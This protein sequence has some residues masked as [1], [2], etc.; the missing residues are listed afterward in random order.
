MWGG[1]TEDVEASSDI[2]T[3][4]ANEGD[5]ETQY[6]ILDIG[7][8][9]GSYRD[10]SGNLNRYTGYNPWATITGYNGANYDYYGNGEGTGSLLG[11]GGYADDWRITA[12]IPAEDFEDKEL[13]IT[14]P[15]DS[16]LPE[17]DWHD[18]RSTFYIYGNEG[19]DGAVSVL[20]PKENAYDY[21]LVGW[22]NIGTGEYYSVKNGNAE[23]T[24]NTEDDNIFY[25]DWEAATY[26]V[27]TD[28]GNVANTV[29][30]DFVTINLFDYNEL[31]NLYSTNYTSEGDYNSAGSKATTANDKKEYWTIGDTFNTEPLGSTQFENV[32]SFAFYDG[33]DARDEVGMLGFP[34]NRMDQSNG[35]DGNQRD[36]TEYQGNRV[37]ITDH[38]G[39]TAWDDAFFTDYLF[40]KN[41]ESDGVLGVDYIGQADQLFKYGKEGDEIAEENGYVG[42]YYYD[43]RYNSASYNQSEGRFYVYNDPTEVGDN[44]YPEGF[45]PYNYYGDSLDDHDGSVNYF[46]GM[47]M[48]VNFYLPN[49]VG[50]QNGNTVD[51]KDM[52]FNFSGDD[53][54]WIFV[55]DE[56]MLDMSGIHNKSYGSI[57]FCTGAVSLQTT[58]TA[59]NIVYT[60]ENINDISGL[61]AGEHTLRVYY[62]ERGGDASNMIVSFNV[63]P[64][65][66]YESDNVGTVTVDKEWQDEDG[67][68]L[69]GTATAGCPDV[70]VGLYE[71][72][73][74]GNESLVEMPVD[75]NGNP[76]YENPVTLSYDADASD[77]G[78]SY[79]WELLNAEKVDAGNY[80]V[81]ETSTSSDYVL[82]QENDELS[83]YDFDCWTIVGET[84][85]ETW[86]QSHEDV[87][88]STGEYPRYQ[89]V[90]TDAASDDAETTYGQ[91]V[92]IDASSGTPS[93][94]SHK[95]TFSRHP[96]ETTI[97]DPDGFETTDGV[98]GVIGNAEVSA[99]DPSVIW[100]LEY[101]EVPEGDVLDVFHICYEVDGTTYYLAVQY[102]GEE[103]SEPEL[104]ISTVKDQSVDDGYYD[105]FYCDEWGELRLYN[106]QYRLV[107]SS[108]D[109]SISVAAIDQDHYEHNNIKIYTLSTLED[110]PY[111]SWTFV[112]RLQTE[113][114]PEPTPTS[115]PDTGTGPGPADSN[116]GTVKTGDTNNIG[117]WIVLMIL[118]AM[119]LIVGY[120]KLRKR[121]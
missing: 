108:T 5:D 90:L 3:L 29:E 15:C 61:A 79:T 105:E 77:Y 97:E 67:N 9:N 89:V 107:L 96:E 115:N 102:D 35:T 101:A 17:S 8:I 34:D 49:V 48:D 84:E 18:D 99:C 25:A 12:A 111:Y 52:T 95:L 80:I 114:T 120:W 63:A 100:Y 110:T 59:G 74:E 92:Y 65:W 36:A 1:G 44:S 76:L 57:D 104:V 72:D 81:K 26:N 98:Y 46:F 58:D 73:D 7:N 93:I 20:L 117:L 70:T 38:L 51:G 33:P 40:N 106:L 85:I 27:G 82:V 2:M 28:D 94:G 42:Y 119:V 16:D 41:A 19:E 62:L 45:Y 30:T 54:I 78:W 22:I 88:T 66:S 13:T 68:T 50:K 69:T 37:N 47:T 23:A 53:D 39:V 21:K 121:V 55:D 109:G 43:S 118:S 24:I 32:G 6:V 64:T 103:D 83:K 87:D 71:K 113:I 60:D 11:Y 4:A 10:D 91:A 75:A 86:L 56:L 112:N 14:L 31:F 116:P